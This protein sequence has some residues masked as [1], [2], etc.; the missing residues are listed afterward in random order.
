MFFALQVQAAF[1][2]RY[3]IT[4]QLEESWCFGPGAPRA[5]EGESHPFGQLLFAAQEHNGTAE[6]QANAT[7]R[8]SYNDDAYRKTLKS[9]ITVS[10]AHGKS[11]EDGIDF[12]EAPLPASEDGVKLKEGVVETKLRGVDAGWQLTY[13]AREASRLGMAWECR[14]CHL[15]GMSANVTYA[16]FFVHDL[17][18][19]PGGAS[20]ATVDGI[21]PGRWIDF[22]VFNIY[23]DNTETSRSADADVAQADAITS[24][25]TGSLGQ[26]LSSSSSP[27]HVTL[28]ARSGA[29]V[30]LYA[31]AAGSKLPPMVGKTQQQLAVP[32]GTVTVAPGA[33][34][35]VYNNGT[36]PARLRIVAT[37]SGASVSSL[38][39][40]THCGVVAL[41]V[42]VLLHTSHKTFS[43]YV[44]CM[45]LVVLVGP[46]IAHL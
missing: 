5:A 23:S 25:D 1:Q 22:N 42:S 33:F 28:D 30:Q 36:V 40:T 4:R 29:G 10:C 44:M 18:P 15:S 11:L 24:T 16:A 20:E 37:V 35:S 6:A 19:A 26:G 39:S 13:L 38:R 7:A 9:R 27:M 3:N 41:A 8:M 17:T 43:H 21:P 46:V 32:G 2:L 34:I 12:D 14:V 31:A 45:L